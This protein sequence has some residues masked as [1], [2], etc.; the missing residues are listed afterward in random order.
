MSF[1]SIS[2]NTPEH[3]IAAFQRD[4]P[5]GM[6][7]ISRIVAQAKSGSVRGPR[8]FEPGSD[9]GKQIIRLM[10]A[11]VPPKTP[12]TASRSSFSLP[13]LLRPRSVSWRWSVPIVWGAIADAIWQSEWRNSLRWLLSIWTTPR[14]TR[15]SLPFNAKYMLC[16]T[17]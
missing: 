10:G 12:R 6:N 1:P 17:V 16:L 5:L 3:F 11:D 8:N 15:I 9:E 13:E 7:A 2:G 4:L 14:E